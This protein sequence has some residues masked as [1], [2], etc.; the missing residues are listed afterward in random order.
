VL[1]GK[2]QSSQERMQKFC[3]RLWVI[4]ALLAEDVVIEELFEL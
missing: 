4:S 2:E 3:D 1:I